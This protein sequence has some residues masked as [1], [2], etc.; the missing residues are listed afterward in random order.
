MGR[1]VKRFEGDKEDF[2]SFVQFQKI[3]NHRIENLGL[4]KMYCM[5]RIGNDG[6]IAVFDGTPQR[7]DL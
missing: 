5:A 4:L 2:S 3:R 1:K 7:L 6:E